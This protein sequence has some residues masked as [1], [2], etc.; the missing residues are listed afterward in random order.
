MNEHIPHKQ[1]ASSSELVKI[2]FE[3]GADDRENGID[4][5]TLWAVPLEGGLYRIDN[6]PFYAYGVSLGD[7]VRA[8]PANGFLAFREVHSRSGHSTY[9]VWIEPASGIGRSEFDTCL[10]E[11][12][13]LG[14]SSELAR[15]HWFAIDVPSTCNISA[16][17]TILEDGEQRGLWW[18]EEAHCGHAP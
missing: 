2:L 1:A 5:E 11:L 7:I 15:E 9:R 18:F 14:C 12:E 3:L 16:V 13:R 17:Y 10:R 8:E 6:S 4:A